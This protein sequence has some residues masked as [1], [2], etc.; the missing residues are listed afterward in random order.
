MPSFLQW[1][2]DFIKQVSRSGRIN[3]V[4]CKKKDLRLECSLSFMASTEASLMEDEKASIMS[5][6][7]KAFFRCERKKKKKKAQQQEMTL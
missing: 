6:D 2:V 7:L 4:F 5:F 3:F 1:N